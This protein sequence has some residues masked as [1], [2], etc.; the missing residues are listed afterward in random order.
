MAL[1][2]FQAEEIDAA[3]LNPGEFASLQSRAA[4]LENLEKLKKDAGSVHAALYEADGS[5]LERL[6]GMGAVLAELTLLDGGSSNRQ[7]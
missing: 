6:K 7:L 1:Y 2:R 4:I 3:E 5:L